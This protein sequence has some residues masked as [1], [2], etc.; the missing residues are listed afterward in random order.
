LQG[1]ESIV[2][3]GQLRLQPGAK[4]AVKPDTGMNPDG[5]MTKAEAT[6]TRTD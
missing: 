3:S 6:S 4:V 1:R 2:T 5:S